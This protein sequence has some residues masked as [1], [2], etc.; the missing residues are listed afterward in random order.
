MNFVG[1]KREIAAV[2]K[3]LKQNRNIVLTG[4]YGVGRSC[5]VK[6]IAR[7]H[8]ATWQFLYA[9]FSKT[10]ARSCNE[11]ISQL[12]AGTRRAQP[13]QYTRLMHAKDILAG[14][15]KAADLPRVIVLDNIGKISRP[16]LAFL[17][18]M[19]LDSDLLFITVTES[20]LP[21][22]DLFRLRAALYPSDMLTLHNLKRKET[23]AFFRNFS[24]RK[25]LGWTASFIQMLAASTGG[26]AL[27]MKEV[28]QREAGL[29]PQGKN[30]SQTKRH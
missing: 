2:I 4:R 11:M 15:N 23:A 9:D 18:D 14:R 10:V 13:H 22:A 21:E 8:A 16:K 3:S 29:A 30:L 17:R 1:R 5:L 12:A 24:Q 25:Q 19:R 6:H 7:L 20:F 26:Y 27:L 28:A